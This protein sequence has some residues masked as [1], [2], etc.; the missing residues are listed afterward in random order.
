M[1]RIAAIMV[2][3]DA[4]AEANI[5][6]GHIQQ[7]QKTDWL[8]FNPLN[9]TPRTPIVRTALDNPAKPRLFH[10][11]YFSTAQ[12][13]C[14]DTNFHTWRPIP[15]NHPKPVKFGFAAAPGACGN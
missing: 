14:L 5:S 13:K 8:D 1:V 15:R 2:F 10:F 9:V 6:V 12:S 7:I 4:T 3:G 11:G